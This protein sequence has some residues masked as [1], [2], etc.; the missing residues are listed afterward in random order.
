MSTLDALIA[1]LINLVRVGA[2]GR[3]IFCFIRLAGTEDESA[4]YKKRIRNTLMF[5]IMTECVYQIK[6]LAIYYFS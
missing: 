2:A 1:V 5:Y 4:M 6:E 3:V